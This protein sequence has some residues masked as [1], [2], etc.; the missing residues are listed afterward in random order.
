MEP[1]SLTFQAMLTRI[2][3]SLP[4]DVADWKANVTAI[5]VT[6]LGAVFLEQRREQIYGLPSGPGTHLE[7]WLWR[8]WPDQTACVVGMQWTPSSHL[9]RAALGA[10]G[11]WEHM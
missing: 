10:D 3:L 11:R 5:L 9:R 4:E 8:S 2:T 6:S 1:G 7:G